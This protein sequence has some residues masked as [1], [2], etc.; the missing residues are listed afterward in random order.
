M[1]QTETTQKRSRESSIDY[2]PHLIKEFRPSFADDPT[3]PTGGA[4][5]GPWV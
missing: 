2:V 3:L 4:I 1:T 5:C